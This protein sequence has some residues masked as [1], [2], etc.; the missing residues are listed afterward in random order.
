MI[1]AEHKDEGHTVCLQPGV[2]LIDEVDAHLHVG[3]Q[4]QLGSWLTSRFPMIQFLVTTHSPFICQAASP[5]GIVRLPAP[6]EDRTIEHIDER[7]FA[8][9]V[10]GGADTAAMSELFGLEH[11]HS[12]RAEKHRTQ[13][14]ELEVKII[15][16]TASSEEIERYEC[17]KRQLPESMDELADRSV[18]ALLAR[19]RRS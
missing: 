4:Q 3:W 5:R 6:G 9:I 11:A 19:G 14:A 2:V 17:L 18:R 8:A 16:G 1:L 15:D 13:I 10:N 7:L 12:E